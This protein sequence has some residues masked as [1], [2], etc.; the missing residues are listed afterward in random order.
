L[1]PDR[2][3]RLTPVS[4]SPTAARSRTGLR[5]VA[6]ACDVLAAHRIVFEAFETDVHPPPRLWEQ[7]G[8]DPDPIEAFRRDGRTKRLAHECETAPV[9]SPYE[10]I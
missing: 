9:E 1:L 10:S 5:E 3:R 8:V 6:P 2:R 7:M 4:S